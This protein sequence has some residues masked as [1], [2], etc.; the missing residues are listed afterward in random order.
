MQTSEPQ[1]EPLA[2]LGTSLFAPEV[3]DL[4]EDTRRYEIAAFVENLDRAKT[5]EPFL[6]RPVIW[7]DDA[8]ALASTHRAVCAL[9]TTRRHLFI[10]QAAAVGFRFATIVHPLSRVSS[11]S[12]VDLGSIVSV[13]AII[14]A[15]TAVGRHV[16]VNRGVLIGHHT[17]IHD[18]VTISPGA[19]IAGGVTVGEGAYIGMGAIVLERLSIGAHAVIGAGAVVTGDVPGHVQVMGIP[20]RITKEQVEGR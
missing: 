5:R 20:A 15:H 9:G 8:A 3:V 12:C 17:T 2:I 19:N 16:I 10:D 18:Y 1:K 7:I 13:G 11:R 14:A 4:A 6:G